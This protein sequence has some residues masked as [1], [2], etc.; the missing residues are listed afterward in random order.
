MAG[1]AEF[2]RDLIRERV[3]SG[4]AAAQARGVKLGRQLGQIVSALEPCMLTATHARARM[5]RG[6]KGQKRPADVIG[7]AVKVMRIA[8][9]EEQED[10]PADDGKDKGRPIVGAAW[11][12]GARRGA[13]RKT[14]A[15]RSPRQQPMRDGSGSW[16]REKAPRRSHPGQGAG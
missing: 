8:T 9:G 10:F 6:P 7:N 11:R 16:E 14:D 15:R 2:E 1:L 13:N 5:P 3:K 12:K 4:L